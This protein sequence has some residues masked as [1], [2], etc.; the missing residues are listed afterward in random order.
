[1]KPMGLI[2]TPFISYHDIKTKDADLYED[3]FGLN[4]E[5]CDVIYLL[6]KIKSVPRRELTEKLIE[7]IRRFN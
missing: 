3:A 4:S 7:K 6:R 5:F 2:S 1:M